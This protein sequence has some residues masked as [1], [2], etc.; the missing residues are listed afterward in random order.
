[1]SPP[2]TTGALELLASW[3]FYPDPATFL[4][5]SVHQVASG[6]AYV[7]SLNILHR[8]IKPN[9]IV[10][11]STSPIHAIIVDFGCS[12]PS[13]TSLRHDRGTIPYLA[14]E[15]MRVKDGEST[16]PFSFPSD[17]WSLGVTLV[18]FLMG[19]QFNQHLGKASVYQSFKNIM[20]TNTVELHHPEFWD[21]VLEILAWVPEVRPTA[22]EVAQR[23]SDQEQSQVG[24]DTRRTSTSED[25]TAKRRKL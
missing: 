15:V 5:D 3:K 20:A 23:L 17:V 11:H 10:Y 12:D 21:L 4:R 7:H 2:A 25:L 18:D 9:N 8:D 22:M 14:P 13:P 19:K 6:L 1:M 24:G 16:Q